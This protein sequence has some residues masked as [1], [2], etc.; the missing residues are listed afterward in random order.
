MSLVKVLLLVAIVGVLVLPV[1]AAPAYEPPGDWVG[2]SGVWVC[3]DLSAK[4]GFSCPW[5]VAGAA[6]YPGG[7]CP[8]DLCFA[9]PAPTASTVGER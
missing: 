5:K 1:S 6:Y 4:N 9:A 7:G 2:I 3:Y 8:P